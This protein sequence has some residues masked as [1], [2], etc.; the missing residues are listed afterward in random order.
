MASRWDASNWTTGKTTFFNALGLNKIAS[1]I[2]F[3]SLN[4]SLTQAAQTAVPAPGSSNTPAGGGGAPVST[5]GASGMKAI[6]NALRSGGA[7]PIQAVGI[8][9]NA[10]NES[11]LDPEV[12]VRDTN[13]A[14]SNGL[15]QFNE[16]SYP[17]SGSLVTGNR[18]NDID[19]QVRYLIQV[20]GLR[21][22]SGST[23]D[24]VAGNFAANF[25]K[26]TECA[27]G[28]AQYNSRVGNVPTVLK[29]LGLG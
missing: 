2:K 11:S 27:V 25:E 6:Y 23:P 24:M 16:A 9:A 4:A 10:M 8:I 17:N 19:A 14:F 3:P 20:G 21:A 7:S 15:F 13:G 29:T 1:Q 18:Q 22:A 5:G 26:C 12:R 28:G